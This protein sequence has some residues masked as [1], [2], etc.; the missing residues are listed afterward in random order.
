MTAETDNT[1]SAGVDVRTS[2]APGSPDAGSPNAGATDGTA[3]T[4][5]PEPDGLTVAL[6]LIGQRWALLIVRELL[7]GPKR[8]G[9]LQRAL[10]RIPTNILTTRLKEFQ[11]TGLAVRV[12][13]AHNALAY[14][15]T[16]RGESLRGAIETLDAWGSEHVH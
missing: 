3:R 12:P 5:E 15:L 1:S 14:R 6:G 13:L 10:P 16:E 7:D 8:F 11:Q 2:S 4:G 9:D